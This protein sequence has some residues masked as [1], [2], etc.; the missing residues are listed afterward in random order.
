MS[1]HAPSD[2][3]CPAMAQHDPGDVSRCRAVSGPEGTRGS[4]SSDVAF[5]PR[6]G[7]DCLQGEVGACFQVEVVRSGR[8]STAAP[9]SVCECELCAVC[10]CARKPQV[11]I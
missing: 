9:A 5:G 2:P 4:V 8:A 7:R 6:E 10:V 1:I 11:K 3:A